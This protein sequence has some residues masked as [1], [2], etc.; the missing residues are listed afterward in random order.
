[1]LCYA[2]LSYITLGAGR[3]IIPHFEDKVVAL[4]GQVGNSIAW[5]GLRT[6]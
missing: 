3:G 2:K 6:V 1:M 5:D 4:L